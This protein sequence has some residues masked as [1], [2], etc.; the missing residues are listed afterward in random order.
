MRYRVELDELL[1]FVEILQA[2]EQRA[3]T[4]AARVDKQVAGLHDSWW[5][6]RLVT[7]IPTGR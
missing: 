5:V 6:V 1:G 7:A 4:I 3:V 2:F